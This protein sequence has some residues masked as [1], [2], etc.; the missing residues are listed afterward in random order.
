M[1]GFLHN[2]RHSFRSTLLGVI[3]IVLLSSY[4]W[5]NRAVLDSLESV[6]TIGAAYS[7]AIWLIGK[8]DKGQPPRLNR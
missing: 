4:V 7:A 3:L 2:A 5:R 8:R 6:A 1:A